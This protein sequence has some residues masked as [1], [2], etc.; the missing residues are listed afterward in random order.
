MYKPKEGVCCGFWIVFLTDV[1]VRDLGMAH[2]ALGRFAK[3]QGWW[4]CLRSGGGEGLSEE[5]LF[6]LISE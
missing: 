1:S 3:A 6:E 4:V 2:Y 5:K